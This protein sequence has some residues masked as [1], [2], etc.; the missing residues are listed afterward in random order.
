MLGPD[1][2]SVISQVCS[3]ESMYSTG[4]FPFLGPTQYLGTRVPAFFVLGHAVAFK[5]GLCSRPGTI[6]FTPQR[7]CIRRTKQ[8]STIYDN[9]PAR[10]IQNPPKPL[11]PTLVR[12]PPRPSIPPILLRQSS[13]P[14]H[15]SP[16]GRKHNHLP[17]PPS[18][19]ATSSASTSSHS[20]RSR[21]GASTTSTAR[22]TRAALGTSATGQRAGSAGSASGPCSQSTVGGQRAHTDKRRTSQHSRCPTTITTARRSAAHRGARASRHSATSTS[23]APCVRPASTMRAVPASYASTLPSASL[24]Q[25]PHTHAQKH[26]C[27]PSSDAQLL[28]VHRVSYILQAHTRRGVRLLGHAAWKP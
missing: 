11:C 27:A 13:R 4:A 21:S 1:G 14:L 3:T 19:A 8:A 7:L 5:S 2:V 10:R 9:R 17:P 22:S 20:A 28:P 25:H 24:H 26:T 18:S 23:S 16:R 12:R 15:T 6:I